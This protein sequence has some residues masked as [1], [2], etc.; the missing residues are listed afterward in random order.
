[1]SKKDEFI[2]WVTALIDNQKEEIVASNEALE[3]WEA[4]K[5]KSDKEKPM[6]TDNGKLVMEY[7][8]T[9]P[10]D[11]QPMKSRDIAE[12]MCIS[13]RTV[14]GTMR[15][16]VSDG[17]VEKIGADPVLYKITEKGR[18]IEIN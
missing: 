14:S 10:T 18:T 4:L 1:M 5:V 15:K 9:L 12:S 11:T 16:L 2:N 17:F 8:Q 3:Y 13:S 6:F 7:L